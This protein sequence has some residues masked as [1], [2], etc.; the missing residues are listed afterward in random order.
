M[1]AVLVP[2]SLM[3][4]NTGRLFREF[5]L[6]MTAA[7]LVSTFVTLTVVPMACSRFLKVGSKHGLV[8]RAIEVVLN[9]MAAVYRRGL[10]LF[11]RWRPVVVVLF[12][13]TLGGTVWLVRQ[14]PRNLV[15]IEDRGTFTTI[16]RA[17]QGATSAYTFRALEQVEDAILALPD[18]ESYFALLS[19]GFGGPGDS[20]QGMVFARLTPWDDRDITQQEVVAGLFPRFMAIPEALV[21]PINP[22][23]LG[24]NRRN[25]P[26]QI[27]LKSSSAGLEEFGEVSRRVV[28]RL[29]RVP[30]LVNVDSDM[31]LD[32]PQLDIV[33]DRER[34]ADLGISVADVAESM[35]LLVSQGRMDDFILKAKQYDVVMALASRYRSVPEQLGEIYLRAGDGTMV[36]MSTVARAVPGIGPASLSHYDLQRSVTVTANLDADSTLGD[37]LPV[38]QSI[39]DEELPSGFGMSLGGTSREFVESAGSMYITFGIALIVIYLVLAAQ[40]ESFLHPLTV[41]LS[42]PLATLGGLGALYWLGHTLNIYSAI[43]LI[44][45]VGLVTKNSIL[46]VDFANQERA[47]GT[48]LFRSLR[49]AGRTRFRP[50]LMTSMTSVLGAI[51]LAAATG[52]GA[53]SRTAIGAVVVG[54]LIF[55]TVFT[56]LMIPTVHYLV[57]RF[58][59]KLGLNTIPPLVEL[60]SGRAS[61]TPSARMSSGAEDGADSADAG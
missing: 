41:M 45:L 14:L 43:G 54:G 30:G 55:S 59:E 23:S 29:R 8:W 10:E 57:V 7:V 20:A 35:R 9:G 53:E 15:P 3:T 27:A 44:L 56:L 37:V 36:P 49:S 46:L 26:V 17:P 31:R 2:L 6:T 24:G 32:N 28:D 1:V 39:I 34:A 33:I 42:V 40:F 52:A 22:E 60:D 61:S 21:F 18:F 5:A 47:R 13:A 50:I 19:F 4:G 12:V 16:I 25:S 51:P 11:L 48:S 38:A 58:G